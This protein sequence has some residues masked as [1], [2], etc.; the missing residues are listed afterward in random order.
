MQT[1][2]DALDAAKPMTVSE[3]T[4]TWQDPKSLCLLCQSLDRFASTHSSINNRITL[5]LYYNWMIQNLYIITKCIAKGQLSTETSSGKSIAMSPSS[6][7]ATSE[8][9]ECRLATLSY[10]THRQDLQHETLQPQRVN[11][12][13][14]YWQ[15][16][17]GEIIGDLS[18]T[19]IFG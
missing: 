6:S 1:V 12:F 13:E 2:S 11:T 15:V 17:L 8:H 3:A 14:L 18:S 7:C 16:F 5:H 9:V 4:R 10:L 19:C